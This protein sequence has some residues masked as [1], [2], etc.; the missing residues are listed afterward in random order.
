MFRNKFLR[1]QKYRYR[2]LK[3]KELD[4]EMGRQIN[5]NSQTGRQRDTHTYRQT[6]GQVETQTDKQTQR[7][8]IDIQR[9]LGNTLME[10]N[11]IILD[12]IVET[13]Y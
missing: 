9:E 6:V 2:E 12:G 4:G 5:T 13:L 11:S 3:E 7:Q 10:N 1:D 8:I